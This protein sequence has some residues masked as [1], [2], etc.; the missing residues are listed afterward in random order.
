MRFFRPGQQFSLML[1]VIGL[2]LAATIR[3]LSGLASEALKI[4][5]QPQQTM[6]VAAESIVLEKEGIVLKILPRA[7]YEITARVLHSQ[8]YSDWQAT[9]VPVDVAL[10]W[11]RI[12]NPVVDKGIEWWQEGRWYFY[13]PRNTSLSKKYIREHSANVHPIPASEMVAAALRQLK[14]N[15]MVVMSGLLV[16]VEAD[17]AGHTYQFFTSLTRLDE[18]DA[19]CEIFYVER[20]VVNGTAI[21]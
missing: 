9:F 17:Y 13:Q 14:V 3:P 5:P 11:G 18:G 1:L 2:S 8:P 16:D 21:R 20:I 7:R 4:T 15:D 6:L 12:G 19:S 10:G